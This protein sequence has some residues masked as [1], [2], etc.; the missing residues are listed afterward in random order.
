NFQVEYAGV[1]NVLVYNSAGYGTG[2]NFTITSRVGLRVTGQ[3][4]DRNAIAGSTTNFSLTAIGQGNL[5][6]QWYF[7]GNPISTSSNL[8]ATNA[9]LTL[10]NIQSSQGGQY[11][12]TVRDD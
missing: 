10:T 6:Y 8:T 5:R 2:T 4:G 3:P 11:F 1:Y 7:N 12:A 9:T